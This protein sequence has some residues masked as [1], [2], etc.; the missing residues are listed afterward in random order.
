MSPF[1]A[2]RRLRR[3]TELGTKKQREPCKGATPRKN[4]REIRAWAATW[5]FRFELRKWFVFVKGSVFGNSLSR[6]PNGAVTILNAARQGFV[7]WGWS[8]NLARPRRAR[9]PSTRH[10]V[11][12]SKRG[13]RTTS[14]AEP[15]KERGRARASKCG[16]VGSHSKGAPSPQGSCRPCSCVLP[17][18]LRRLPREHGVPQIQGGRELAL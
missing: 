17:P 9:R 8:R 6:A 7:D 15:D 11:T 16:S 18:A 5:G 10:S 3:S 13:E 4:C 14:P 2:C 12:V 1:D